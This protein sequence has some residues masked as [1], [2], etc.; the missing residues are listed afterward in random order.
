MHGEER[1]SVRIFSPIVP[2]TQAIVQLKKCLAFCGDL[3]RLRR[4]TSV[5]FGD[6]T[7][8]AFEEHVKRTRA[9]PALPGLGGIMQKR[10]DVVSVF[11]ACR[12]EASAQRPAMSGVVDLL[13]DDIHGEDRW[14]VPREQLVRL[15]TLGR[16][17][18]GEVFKMV[19]DYF[20]ASGEYTFVAVKNLLPNDADEQEQA[21]RADDFLQEV[22]LMKRLRHPNLVSLLGVCMETEPYL[23]VLE[24]STGG[25]LDT[26]LPDNGPKL[27]LPELTHILHQ[28][29]LGLAALSYANVIHRDLA[30][31]NVL[32]GDALATKIADYG[33]SRDVT[34]ERDYY[35]IQ[36]LSRPLPIRWCAPE[37]LSE[38]LYSVASDV[39]SFGVLIFEVFSFGEYPF[40]AVNDQDFI[41]FLSDSLEPLHARLAFHPRAPAAPVIE[42]IMQQALSRDRGRRYVHCAR[43]WFAGSLAPCSG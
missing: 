21:Q 2:A 28:V 41:A 24:F 8:A 16:G 36:N 33:M 23:I 19:T 6:L 4:P 3:R 34:A 18:F 14:Q 26:W 38:L 15:E 17:E 37:V 27:E 13:L 40:D 10:Q 22:E 31:R 25:S 39:Y 11:E 5:P 32:I 20:S 9:C 7:E 1:G 30:A 43:L 12:Q 35:R 42:S 29:A